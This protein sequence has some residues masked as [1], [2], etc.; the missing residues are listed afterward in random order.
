M[1]RKVVEKSLADEGHPQHPTPEVI[2]ELHSI[3]EKRRPFKKI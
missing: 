1:E 2:L 3:K